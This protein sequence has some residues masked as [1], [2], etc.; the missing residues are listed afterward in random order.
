MSNCKFYAD[1]D[2]RIDIGCPERCTQYREGSGLDVITEGISPDRLKEI[3]NAERKKR[4][5]V[6]PE[7]FK[8]PEPSFPSKVEI[9]AEID[10]RQRQA[11]EAE[12]KGAQ[13]DD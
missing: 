4:L 3:C 6:L 13:R 8:A 9:L 11:A 10:R 1:C 2:Y 5:M 7:G 12:L